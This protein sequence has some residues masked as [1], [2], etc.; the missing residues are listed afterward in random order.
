M[1]VSLAHLLGCGFWGISKFGR[2]FQDSWDLEP[3]WASAFNGSSVSYRYTTALHWS[4]TQF[5]PAS[6]D[7][8]PTNTLE[9]AYSVVVIMLA[10]VVFSSF[11]SSITA[12]M[13]S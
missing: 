7:L 12:A 9:R 13:T 1:I 11:V 6:M 10:L 2:N 8:H 4:L 3:G 5:T